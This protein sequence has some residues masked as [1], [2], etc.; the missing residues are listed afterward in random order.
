MKRKE[1][2]EREKEWEQKFGVLKVIIISAVVLINV[3]TL[4][5][6]YQINFEFIKTIRY[7]ITGELL[8][9]LKYFKILLIKYFSLL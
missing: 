8:Y 3:E 5:V 6:D 7:K 1:E 9:I 4:T 2:E